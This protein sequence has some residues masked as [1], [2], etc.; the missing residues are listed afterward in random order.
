MLLSIPLIAALVAYFVRGAPGVAASSDY[1]WGGVVGMTVG[2]LVMLLLLMRVW[3]GP[4]MTAELRAYPV[5]YGGPLLL[6]VAAVALI[7]KADGDPP[8][9]MTRAQAGFVA[10]FE[11]SCK[12]RRGPERYCACTA[13]A[14]VD[15]AHIVTGADVERLGR[16][17]QRALR[18]GRPS[19]IPVAVRSAMID[20][21]KRY[22]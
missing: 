10:G 6:V 18:T 1:R 13:R 19:D 17:M 22:S 3:M 8:A 20:C 12:A 21:A 2:V 16:R 5:H 11:D 4:R 15:R 7:A 14:V 9:G